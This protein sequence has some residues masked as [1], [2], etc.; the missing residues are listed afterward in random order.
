MSMTHE[1]RKDGFG[2]QY[3]GIITTYISCIKHNIIYKYT[4]LFDVEHNYDN[5]PNYINQ[6][7]ELMN[8]KNNIENNHDFSSTEIIF[9]NSSVYFEANID[10]CCNSDAMK[11][12]K[13]CFWQNKEKDYFK[14]NKMNISIHIRRENSHDRGGAG[15][16]ITTPNIYYLNIMNKIREQYNNKELLFHVYSQGSI[17][18]FR[19]FEKE[20]VQFH[21]N[22]QIPT[23]FI[24]LVAADIL[25]ISPSS[26]SYIAALL[27]DGIVYYK[28]FWH[29]PKKD[30][31]I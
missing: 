4:P 11:F 31:I 2:A 3:Q 22:E 5:D 16:R 21:L 12:I 26:F 27:S 18:N 17:E 23:T 1:N 8:L 15:D 6:L 25:I 7:E 29:N 13:E 10:E 9:R 19:D 30:W 28:Q 14:N 20:D 24:G